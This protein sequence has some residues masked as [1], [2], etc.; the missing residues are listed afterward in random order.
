MNTELPIPLWRRALSFLTAL[1][2]LISS[3]SPATAQSFGDIVGGDRKNAEM[4]NR[5]MTSATIADAKS[6][7]ALFDQLASV[8][9][10]IGPLGAVGTGETYNPK[11]TKRAAHLKTELSAAIDAYE[12]ATVEETRLGSPVSLGVLARL[13]N[14]VAPFVRYLEQLKSAKGI[15]SKPTLTV[16]PGQIA[17]FDVS[18]YCMDSSLGTPKSG[19]TFRLI[20]VAKLLPPEMAPLYASIMQKPGKHSSETQGLVWA[21]RNAFRNG[22]PITLSTEAIQ[23]LDVEYP[24]AAQAITN[25]NRRSGNEKAVR[26]LLDTFLPGVR[27]LATQVQALDPQRMVQDTIAQVETL[28]S[29]PVA[30]SI[31]PLAAYT[32]IA[33]GIAVKATSPWGGLS[34]ARVEIA[35][36]TGQPYRFV[37]AEWA[38]ASPRASQHLALQTPEGFS[39]D[40]SSD[41]KLPLAELLSAGLDM[42]VVGNIKAAIQAITGRDLITDAETSRWV[43]LLGIIPAIGLPLKLAAKAAKANK[44][45]PFN[46]RTA[47]DILSISKGNR[48]LPSSYLPKSYIDAHKKKFSSGASRF[49][50]SD[51]HDK[52]GIAQADGTSFIFPKSEADRMAQMAKSDPEALEEFL[53]LPKGEFKDADIIQIDIEPKQLPSLGFRIPS[54]NEAGANAQWIPGGVLPNG[55]PEAVINGGK[56]KPGV[57]YKITRIGK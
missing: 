33:P 40:T 55:M 20:P 4:R 2:L 12:L 1:S 34:K 22:S 25:Y 19:E 27:N 46:G 45:V 26:G 30:G 9:T 24:G 16:L 11:A 57:Q 15:R 17:T 52:Y 53:G 23:R 50:R 13:K 5:K 37:P 44:A 38:A 28:T 43:E 51:Q 29:M 31:E 49:M 18:A 7:K 8:Q 21:I 39:S 41:V 35:N 56:M 48:P 3:I 47:E 10:K 36:N 14:A 42:S 54:G 6:A 32:N